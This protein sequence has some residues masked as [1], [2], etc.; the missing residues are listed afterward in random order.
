[1]LRSLT[2]EFF[3]TN[4]IYNTC[5]FRV[6]HAQKSTAS[7]SLPA[8]YA[9]SLRSLP[10]RMISLCATRKAGWNF[11]TLTH[12]FTKP[13]SSLQ[14][15]GMKRDMSSPGLVKLVSRRDFSH[16]LAPNALTLFR[17]SGM[18]CIARHGASGTSADRSN[19]RSPQPSSFF[20]LPSC[21]SWPSW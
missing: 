1:M 2:A 21:S 10:P 12:W 9:I 14:L 11:S 20:C 8:V 5:L 4:Q 3:L 7:C 19:E 6:T 13:S 17:R 16:Q 18:V 15:R